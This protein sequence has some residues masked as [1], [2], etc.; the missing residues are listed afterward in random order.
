[1]AFSKFIALAFAVTLVTPGFSQTGKP[2]KDFS[3]YRLIDLQV[4]GMSAFPHEKLMALFPIR[5][6]NKANW[7]QI[8]KGIEGI[9]RLFEEAGYLDFRYTPWFD[10]DRQSKT[11]AC[12]FDLMQ[13]RQYIVRRLDLVGSSPLSESKIR[14]ALSD[15]GLEEGKIF[16]ISLLD[17]AVKTINKLLGSQELNSNRYEYKKLVDSP[18]MVDVTIR[19]Q[20]D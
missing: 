8:Q 5:I 7:T 15:L 9:K 1:M 3:D 19:L 2:P 14:A 20:P 10:V 12:S 18:G 4:S 13:G 11:V 16:R 6:G 17:G